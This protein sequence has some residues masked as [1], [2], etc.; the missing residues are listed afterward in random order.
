MKFFKKLRPLIAILFPILLITGILIILFE[1]RWSF[2]FSITLPF[3]VIVTFMQLLFLLYRR[4]RYAFLNILSLVLFF[5]FF[6][7]FYQFNFYSDEKQGENS[8]SILS[9]NAN[10]SNFAHRGIDYKDKKIVEF[11]KQQNADVVCFQEF[12]AIKYHLFRKDYPHWVKTNLMT[13]KQKS[14]LSVFSK[15]PIL[16]EGYVEFLDSR[17]NAMFVDI[18]FNGKIV[19]LYNIHLESNRMDSVPELYNINSYTN[20]ISR[21]CDAEIKRIEQAHLIKEHMKGF[22]GNIIITGDFNCTQYSSAYLVLKDTKK[23]TFVEAGSGFGGTYELF[24]YP[25]KIDH[26]LVDD[27]IEVISHKNFKIGLSDHEPI[28]AEIKL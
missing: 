14:V 13:R 6:D 21:S 5:F 22:G 1:W 18:D 12:S 27:E 3:L 25:F 19:R 17:N 2:P 7:S 11:I 8:V 16:N 23:D 24:N 15:Y 4:R 20:L 26:I 9:Y 10:W 28:M